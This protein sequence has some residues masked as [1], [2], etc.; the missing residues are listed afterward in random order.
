MPFRGAVPLTRPTM[1]PVV[2]HPVNIV[3]EVPRTL[4]R[5]ASCIHRMAYV[6]GYMLQHWLDLIFLRH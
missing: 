1:A 2:T 6:L 4:P 3:K 5:E